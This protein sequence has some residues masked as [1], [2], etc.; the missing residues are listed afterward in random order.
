METPRE[1]SLNEIW[2]IDSH[3]F[4]VTVFEFPDLS[5]FPRFPEEVGNPIYLFLFRRRGSVWSDANKSAYHMHIAQCEAGR[6]FI[7]R[8][9]LSLRINRLV[10]RKGP[11]WQQLVVHQTVFQ[12]PHHCSQGSHCKLVLSRRS[13]TQ[14][15]SCKV[16]TGE[17]QWQQKV[18]TIRGDNHKPT[19]HL[20]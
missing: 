13:V 16:K 9:V 7:S 3:N 6:L 10:D 20:I 4:S 18:V 2:L 11:K 19:K 12:V 8:R 15:I 1:S 17:W 14:T 5:G